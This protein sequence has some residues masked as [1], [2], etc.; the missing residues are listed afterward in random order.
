MLEWATSGNTSSIL[1]DYTDPGIL[2]IVSSN[3]ISIQGP[4]DFNGYDVSSIKD[5]ELTGSATISGEILASG[6]ITG[7]IL[8]GIQ[9]GLVGYDSTGKLIIGSA[10]ADSLQDSYDASTAI[11]ITTDSTRGAL[12]L[13]NGQGVAN[14]GLTV[15]EI[16]DDSST[17]QFEVTG[18]GVASAN[19]FSIGAGQFRAT[20]GAIALNFSGSNQADIYATDAYLFL[21]HA[22]EVIIGGATVTMNGNLEV[23]GDTAVGDFEA[24]GPA[25]LSAGATIGGNVSL[26]SGSLTLSTGKINVKSGIEV[27]SIPTG[28]GRSTATT[29][30]DVDNFPGGTMLLTENAPSM[31]NL[32]PS[33]PATGGRHTI[34]TIHA[35]TALGSQM[36]FDTGTGG[37]GNMSFRTKQNSAGGFSDWYDTA[38]LNR[39][40]TFTATQS[41]RMPAAGTIPSFQVLNTVNDSVIEMWHD[42]GD[43]GY[44]IVKNSLGSTIFKVNPD[45]ANPATLLPTVYMN[46]R[47]SMVGLPTSSSGLSVGNVWN[48][49]G[50]LMAQKTLSNTAVTASSLGID[51]SQHDFYSITALASPLTITTPSNGVNGSQL[52]I[53][54]KDD[55]G[56]KV[57]TFSAG[58]KWLD[59]SKPTQT[60]GGKTMYI[61]CRYNSATSDWEV[62]SLVNDVATA[63]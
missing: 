34:F 58:F 4:T 29:E 41:V 9:Q 39:A 31:S 1:A 16:K 17:T 28:L 15:L 36:A 11:E 54:I 18:E 33:F 55:G 10:A 30:L 52:M 14:D 6:P 40:Q 35:T 3:G 24:S 23:N 27:N 5:L 26:T 44:F 59:A 42:G 49:D 53:R 51:A 62:V 7:E 12:T 13:K 56:A 8:S 25:T 43:D 60:T 48:K 61:D 38:A 63:S 21:D 32:P 50:K 46:G 37:T 19:V 2:G 57:L 22:T 47:V 20:T 45:G